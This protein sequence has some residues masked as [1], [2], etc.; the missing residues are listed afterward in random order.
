MKSWEECVAAVAKEHCA[1][2][3]QQRGIRED[4][5]MWLRDQRLLG[6][7][8][9]APAF[10]IHGTTG[11]VVG[12]HYHLLD[13]WR[14]AWFVEDKSQQTTTPLIIGNPA[15]ADWRFV[16]ESQWDAFAVVAA[17]E[18]DRRP[19]ELER[20]CI[21]ITR[22]ASNGHLIARLLSPTCKT[23]AFKQNDKPTNNG[24]LPAA[25]QWLVDVQRHAGC[26][27]HLVST[28]ADFKDAN[29]WL[30]AGATAEAFA[31]AVEAAIL[32]P[33]PPPE[34]KRG[35]IHVPDWVESGLVADESG[36]EREP[37][38][39]HLFPPPF[40]DM[41][42]V[43][44]QINGLSE[45]VAGMVVLAAISACIGSGLAVYSLYRDKVTRANLYLLGA[46]ASGEGKSITFGSLFK[47][48]SDFQADLLDQ[49]RQDIWPKAKARQ[50]AL[51]EQFDHVKKKVGKAKSPEELDAFKTQLALI[52]AELLS[53]E[54][55]LIEPTLV[56]E[57]T[58]SEMLGVVMAQNCETAALISADAGDVIN[59]IAGRYRKGEAVDDNL[60][61][62]GFSGDPVKVSRLNRPSISL[63][64]PC[65]T[66]L[67]LL[68]PDKLSFLMSKRKLVDGGLMPRFLMIHPQCAPSHTTAEMMA[69]P[70][71]LTRA[72]SQA[73]NALT[74]AFRFA[75]KPVVIGATMEARK[76]IADYHNEIADRRAGDLKD[77]ASF[78]ARW[79]E[80]ACRLGVDIHA[81]RHGAD[82][83]KFEIQEDTTRAGME[84]AQWFAAEQLSILRVNR[85]HLQEQVLTAIWRLG[86]ASSQGFT[87]RDVQRQGIVEEADQAKAIL[88]SMVDKGV[89]TQ[90]QQD[91]GGRPK[92]I[93]K[94]QR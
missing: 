68:Q 75:E 61:V 77:V 52:E 73:L 93:F 39:T 83:G 78:A 54:P 24:H 88:A 40:S 55:Q 6:L 70:G 16:F 26:P 72:Y 90:A 14:C 41:I 13:T 44:S 49:W 65:L 59:N 58:T 19:D 94:I 12:C 3:A 18:F 38:P 27:V 30:R 15:T 32:L 35:Q 60:Y 71:E 1:S 87:I 5:F 37:F 8:S 51:R 7:Y 63:R 17:Y 28:P 36:E 10:P 80:Q 48:I 4:L 33:P 91:T 92:V 21:V 20:G 43:S 69:I 45:S 89:L 79:H 62:K 85:S 34:A 47:P 25:D 84:L 86:Q 74:K 56:V 66:M 9:G 82:A 42:R 31:K 2:L 50:A 46:L 57:D 23:Y 22:G 76:V 64:S 67:L 53:V 29:D 81:A 11:T